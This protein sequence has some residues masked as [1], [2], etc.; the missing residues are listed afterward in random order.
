[1]D[2]EYHCGIQFCLQ[3]TGGLEV[4]SYGARRA[5]VMNANARLSV[6]KA[7][8][9]HLIS[10][11]KIT[12]E[13]VKLISLFARFVWHVVRERVLELDLTSISEIVD[14]ITF[15]CFMADYPIK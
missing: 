15:R 2:S 14:W 10:M 7:S 3:V 4:T 13:G 1:M 5:G 8:T 9:F 6:H 12:K 11:R